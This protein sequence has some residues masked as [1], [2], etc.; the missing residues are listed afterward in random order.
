MDERDRV[1]REHL[2]AAVELWRYVEESVRWVFGD[3]LGEV[4]ADRC[5]GV[6]RDAS[7]SGL[8]RT[9]LRDL[10]LGNK[11]SSDRISDALKLLADAGLA[12][13]VMELTGG[14]SAERWF[15]VDGVGR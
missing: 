12:R 4:V 14:R 7:P 13:R 10:E 3:R 6:L 9:E 11:M 15:A 2:L 1:L 5:L 8:T